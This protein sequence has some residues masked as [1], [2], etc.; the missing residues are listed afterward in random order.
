MSLDT[1][2]MAPGD[3]VHLRDGAKS[4]AD[5]VVVRYM[6]GEYLIRFDDGRTEFHADYEL[7]PIRIEGS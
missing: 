4:G 1:H 5:G 3:K 7:E 2:D 6:E